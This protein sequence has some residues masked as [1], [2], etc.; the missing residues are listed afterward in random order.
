MSAEAFF[1]E[2]GSKEL[3]LYTGK[4]QSVFNAINMQILKSHFISAY[5][6]KS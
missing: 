2:D 3:I 4:D 5:A 1:N 6:V